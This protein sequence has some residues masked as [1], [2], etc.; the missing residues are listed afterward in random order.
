MHHL[1]LIIFFI[2]NEE[3]FWGLNTTLQ[4]MSEPLKA[5]GVIWRS[6]FLCFSGFYTIL[7]ASL[8]R[9]S[10]RQ[11]SR[12]VPSLI[13]YWCLCY[14]FFNK[15][16]FDWINSLTHRLRK[17]SKSCSVYCSY[18]EKASTVIFYSI[19]K[20]LKSLS[21]KKPEFVCYIPPS[22]SEKH[23]DGVP[24]ELR[25]FLDVSTGIYMLSSGHLCWQ[26][27]A[28]TEFPPFLVLFLINFKVCNICLFW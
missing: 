23:R 28:L 10:L 17:V 11:D 19:K 22:S 7:C 9:Y 24:L 4:T 1:C 27:W 26:D 14:D 5:G 8:Y 25:I 13:Q 12:W 6:I 18:K 16:I 20:K 15:V 3:I 2:L 21:S